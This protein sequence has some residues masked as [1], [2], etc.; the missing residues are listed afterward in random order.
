M[1]GTKN[2]MPVKMNLL[3]RYGAVAALT[4]L[5][6]LWFPMVVTTTRDL[7]LAGWQIMKHLRD[8]PALSDLQQPRGGEY[9]LPP[10][11]QVM[12]YFLRSVNA[13]TFRFSPGI[14]ADGPT[15]QRLVEGAYPIRAVEV[16]PFYLYLEQEPLPAGCRTIMAEG[17][18]ALAHCP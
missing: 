5:S 13:A 3:A 6:L 17:G 16:S 9:V 7:H 15:M 4:I 1:T 8:L 11:V 12:V 10:R 14:G 2:E 18:V